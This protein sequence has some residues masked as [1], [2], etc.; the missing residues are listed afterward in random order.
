MIPFPK[1]KYNRNNIYHLI[2][3][4]LIGY[5]DIGQWY[6]TA[7]RQKTGCQPGCPLIFQKHFFFLI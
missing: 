2:S 3:H 6:S 1:E 7:D 4:H 5:E